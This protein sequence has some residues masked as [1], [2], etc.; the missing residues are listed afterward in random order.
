MSITTKISL[1]DS[2]ANKLWSD[3]GYGDFDE[4]VASEMDKDGDGKV[5]S[6]EI[7]NYVSRSNANPNSTLTSPGVSASES[8]DRLAYEVVDIAEAPEEYSEMKSILNKCISSFDEIASYITRLVANKE[9]LN[10][11]IKKI[12]TDVE[13]ITI[14]D[15][16]GAGT[17]SAYSLTLAGEESSEEKPQE[18]ESSLANK[19]AAK[20]IESKN[21][22]SAA[23]AQ[24]LNGVLANINIASTSIQTTG[25]SVNKIMAKVSDA[26]TGSQNKAQK[27][28]KIGAVS[29]A[30]SGIAEL[31]LPGIGLALTATV[32]TFR[33]IKTLFSKRDEKAEVKELAIEAQQHGQ[34]ANTTVNEARS[35]IVPISDA[36]S[37]LDGKIEEKWKKLNEAKTKEESES[38]AAGTTTPVITETD[39]TKKPV[40]KGIATY[41]G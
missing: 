2:A 12:D 3:S 28:I 14:A 15:S 39:T 20:T 9:N 19:Q 7:S 24:S 30:V 34:T 22:E 41:G 11:Q 32:A 5:T 40:K 25:E 21:T 23:I 27:I 37:K 31:T 36:H 35:S 6:T 16:T 29:L 38:T 8:E 17:S 4:T 1:A 18:S 33:I 26:S 13:A 10:T